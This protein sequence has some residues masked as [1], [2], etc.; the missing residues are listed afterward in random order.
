MSEP[1]VAILEGNTFVVSD[2]H[3][4]IE[5]SPRDTH[6]LFADDTRFLSRWVLTLDGRRPTLLS[7]HDVEHYESRFFL[8]A[9]SGTI[10]ADADLSLMRKRTVGRGF[11]E[12]IVLTSH[13]P[14]LRDH[15][16]VLEAGADFVDLFE[17]K[18]WLSKK[19]RYYRLTE[20]GALVFG[21]RRDHYVCETRISTAGAVIEESRLRFA[22]RLA[23]RG[24]WR[25]SIDVSICSPAAPANLTGRSETASAVRRATAEQVLAGSP[26]VR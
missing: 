11:S 16:L 12:Q 22:V 26:R 23:P 5:S 6:G 4:D 7:T 18:D 3:G 2:R 24:E 15:E 25:T 14:I 1:T 19:G 9:A 8:A 13:A 10:Y 20:R 21:Y 17:I